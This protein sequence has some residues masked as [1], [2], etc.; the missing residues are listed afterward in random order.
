MKYTLF[1]VSTKSGK[2]HHAVAGHRADTF[3]HE[4]SDEM[5][6]SF[7]DNWIGEE[8]SYYVSW[9]DAQIYW[10]FDQAGVPGL[11]PACMA[12]NSDYANETWEEATDN[13]APDGAQYLTWYTVGNPVY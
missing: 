2:A 12:K 1:L 8:K 7:W 6:E 13:A 11:E 3:D 10:I 4:Y 9:K 5:S